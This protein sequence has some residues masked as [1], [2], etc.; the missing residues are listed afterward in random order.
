M[1]NIYFMLLVA[2]FEFARH[3][4]VPELE[5]EEDTK[6]HENQNSNRAP[7]SRGNLDASKFSDEPVALRPEDEHRTEEGA[8]AFL[9]MKLLLEIANALIAKHLIRSSIEKK[10]L[11]LLLRVQSAPQRQDVVGIV[12]AVADLGGITREDTSEVN[13]RTNVDLTCAGSL[14][15][16]IERMYGINGR[17]TDKVESSQ[18][19]RETKMTQTLDFAVKRTID[20]LLSKIEPSAIYVLT[21]GDNTTRDTYHWGTGVVV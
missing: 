7:S 10:G 6:V 13:L 12:E 20:H 21:R 14:Q 4:A 16:S 17:Q 9:T 2:R 5:V 18:N 3:S 8:E 19:E 11:P 15:L 1:T